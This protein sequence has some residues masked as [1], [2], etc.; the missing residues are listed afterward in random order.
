MRTKEKNGE[1]KVPTLSAIAK[2]ASARKYVDHWALVT[3]L[4]DRTA[5]PGCR[6][7]SLTFILQLFH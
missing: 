7:L 3:A 6:F 4:C 1:E 5:Q 2:H